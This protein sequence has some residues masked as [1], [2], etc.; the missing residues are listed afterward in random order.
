[1]P[2]ETQAELRARWERGEPVEVWFG[3][4]KSWH[5]HVWVRILL[6]VVSIPIAIYIILNLLLLFSTTSSSGS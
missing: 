3:P 1:M 5:Q 2:D 6:V 4:K